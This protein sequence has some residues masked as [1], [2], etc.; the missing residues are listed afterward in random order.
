MTQA[1][2]TI[3]EAHTLAKHIDA[4]N[5]RVMD[6]RFDLS[7]KVAGRR[8]Y[9][10]GHLPNALFAHL[11]EDLSGPLGDRSGR[12]PL[13]AAKALENKFSDWGID[14]ATQLV[15]YDGQAGALASRL[16]WLSRWLGHES[17]AVL[18]G[19]YRA[20]CE[21]GLPVTRAVPS[22]VRKGFVARVDN[23]LW[24]TS[25]EVEQELARGEIRLIDARDAIRFSGEAE[26]LDKR[27]GHIPGSVNLPF[28]GNLD[29]SGRFLTP[30][31]LQ[32]RFSGTVSDFA[33]KNIV[34]SCGSG[35]TACHN[36]LAME[37]IGLTGSRLYPGSWSEWIAGPDRQI[38][39]GKDA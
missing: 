26:P 15:V 27:A 25:D 9:D 33:L 5:W 35:V 31:D 14:N 23:A 16:W 12:H 7:D 22:I 2:T 38:R 3:I 17:V 28:E 21:A 19:G 10:A 30:Q 6:C 32:A 13:P 8:S 39:I 20:W 4:D 37:I 1:Y 29:A 24:L 11:E 34:H 18:N 36:I